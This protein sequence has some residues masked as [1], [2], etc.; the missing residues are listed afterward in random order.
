MI[1]F[2]CQDSVCNNGRLYDPSLNFLFAC[3]ILFFPPYISSFSTSAYYHS[4]EVFY[5]F[6]FLFF[7]LSVIITYFQIACLGMQLGFQN[8]FK[9][10][11]LIQTKGLVYRYR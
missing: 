2:C 7:L 6:K 1:V 10:P 5:A 11:K 4:K 8:C 9:E 3:I